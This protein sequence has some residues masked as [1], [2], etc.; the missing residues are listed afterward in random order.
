MDGANHYL[1]V[2]PVFLT[3]LMMIAAALASN[4]EVGS[5]INTI[6]GFATSSTTIVNQLRDHLHQAIQLMLASMV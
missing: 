1:P 4:L 5:S 3:V 6:E 2:S